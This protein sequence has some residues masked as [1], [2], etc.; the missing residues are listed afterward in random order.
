[1]QLVV[2]AGIENGIVAVSADDSPD[3]LPNAVFLQ[4]EGIF[5]FHCLDL[6]EFVDRHVFGREHVH[7]DQIQHGN[8]LKEVKVDAG[9]GS[10]SPVVAS[11]LKINPPVNFE[12][13][14]SYGS[15]VLGALTAVYAAAP[16]C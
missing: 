8:L 10:I 11:H 12:E 9:P 14:A 1:M 6:G 2:A 7:S 15:A 5:F 16:S 3:M 4:A 13:I